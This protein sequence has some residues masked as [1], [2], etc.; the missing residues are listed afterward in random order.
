M[1]TDLQ[2]K[3]LRV[4]EDGLVRRVGGTRSIYVDTRVIAAMN[5]PPDKAIEQEKLRMDLFYRLNILSYELPPLRERPG[6]IPILIRRFIRHYNG[7]L[8]KEIKGMD[9]E[10]TKRFCR[11]IWPGNVR[12]LKHAVEWMM[13]H[14]EG[15]VLEKGDLPLS[16]KEAGSI[17]KQEIMPL[18]QALKEMEKD[19]I[20]RALEQTGGNV[21]RASRL[22]DIPR[23]TLQYKMHKAGM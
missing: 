5:M 18:R 12:E 9:E 3:L 11:H 7:M 16:L 14:S 2:A 20:K 22:L 13:N 19:Y 23:Q 8:G 15:P 17:G 1:P 21:L 10:T 6:D 4:L